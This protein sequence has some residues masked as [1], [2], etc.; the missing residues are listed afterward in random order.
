[1]KYKI[2]CIGKIKDQFY[3]DEIEKYCENVRLKGHQL[4]VIEFSDEKIPE[5][6][7]DKIKK[8]ILD[9]ECDR[10]YAKIAKRDYVIALCIEGKEITSKQHQQYLELARDN[11]CEGVVYLIGGSLGLSDTIKSRAN[12]KMSFSKMTFPHQMM[13]MVLCEEIS[14][15]IMS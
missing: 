11:G 3:K 15:C 8:Q 12:L 7:N 2:L 4:E 9:K 14:R 6:L 1:M 5:H 13:R 10:M